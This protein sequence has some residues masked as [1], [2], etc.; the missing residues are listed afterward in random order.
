[1]WIDYTLLFYKPTQ[2]PMATQ[3]RLV[4]YICNHQKRYAAVCSHHS[5]QFFLD[6]S[7]IDT[8]PVSQLKNELTTYEHIIITATKLQHQA[9]K[10]NQSLLIHFYSPQS[11]TTFQIQIHSSIITILYISTL[12]CHIYTSITTA[13]YHILV[14]DKS[15]WVVYQVIV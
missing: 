3:L 6:N 2:G 1:M 12:G 14:W 11:S 10:V 9:A 13:C 7:T 8:L 15:H 4:K 5:H